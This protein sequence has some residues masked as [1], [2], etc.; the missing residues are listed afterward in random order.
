[1]LIEESST[2]NKVGSV[3][4]LGV[5]GSSHAF[6][7][8][9]PIHHRDRSLF[10]PHRRSDAGGVT[11]CAEFEGCPCRHWLCCDLYGSLAATGKGHGTDKAIILGFLG[12]PPESVEVDRI[13]ALLREVRSTQTPRLP[14]GREIRFDEQSDLVF[15]RRE[16]LPGRSWSGLLDGCRRARRIPRRH[17]Q[18][19]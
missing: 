10:V 16:P 13:P 2:P 9:R 1:M 11:L 8:P 15:R 18:T 14:N 12:E 7:H 5:L 19:G 4:P 3:I 6:L 17:S